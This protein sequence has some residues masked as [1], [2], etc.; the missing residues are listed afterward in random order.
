MIRH[1]GDAIIGA[2]V[3]GVIYLALAQMSLPV[4]AIA[5]LLHV[6]TGGFNLVLGVV[7]VILLGV[8]IWRRRPGFA[9][10]P[11]LFAA[12]WTSAAVVERIRIEADQD[13]KLAERRAPTELANIRTLIFESQVTQ[14]CCGQ[15]TLLAERKI[16]RYVHAVLDNNFKLVRV[17]SYRLVNGGECTPE[18]RNRS[19]LL[20]RAGRTDECIRQE[21]LD[22]MPDG[23]VIRMHPFAAAY[24]AIGC[25]NRGTISVRENGQE[26]LVTTWH[27]G[28]RPVLSLLP[29]FGTH[30]WGEART[31]WSFGG[32]PSQ[33]V[34]LGGPA[35]HHEDL[36]AAIYRID[37]RA[38]L[39]PVALASPELARRAVALAQRPKF[40][41]RLP[42]LDIVTTLQD[43][44]YVDD[45]ILDVMAGFIEFAGSGLSP[46]MPLLRF[47]QRLSDDNKRKFL[48]RVFMRLEDPNQGADFNKTDLSLHLNT[49]SLAAYAKRA[50]ELF[51][52]RGDLKPWQYELALRLAQPLSR[53]FRTPAYFERQRELFQIVRND[54]GAGFARH[55]IG[56]K[57]VYLTANDEERQ[58]FARQLDR[59]PD[60]LLVEYLRVTGFYSIDLQPAPEVL[61]DYRTKARVRIAAIVNEVERKQMLQTLRLDRPD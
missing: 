47:W 57:R 58:F 2:V 20:A 59:V 4:I 27:Y 38:P 50:E 25:C 28:K 56:F 16:D 19:V 21:T 15:T 51:T 49:A 53:G 10:G 22:A 17:E 54:G 23:V 44:G 39:A 61:R 37:W 34:E 32:G 45:A 42:A 35:F 12:V 48:D 8:S 33:L 13:P 55:A 43:R 6:I 46:S 29:L 3:F 24:A 9:V 30:G 5:Y 31:L 41:D 36:A 11:L 14:T 7:L 40:G 26:R 60:A 18:D 1:T 52:T